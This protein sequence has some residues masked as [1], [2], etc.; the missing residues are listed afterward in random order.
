MTTT[1]SEQPLPSDLAGRYRVSR[2]LGNGGMGWVLLAHD[3]E[4]NGQEVALKLLYPQLVTDQSS[5]D[6]FRREVL[7]ARRLIH[8]NIVRTYNFYSD[9]HQHFL[10]MEYVDA[11]SLADRLRAGEG[12]H[13]LP[14]EECISVLL[15]IAD[16]LAYAH[17]LGVVHLDLKPENILCAGDGSAKIADFGIAQLL[18]HADRDAEGQTVGTPAYMAPEQ[19]RGEGA[20]PRTDI[21][22][23]GILTFELLTGAA[24]FAASTPF[25][26]AMKH[27]NDPLPLERLSPRDLPSWILELLERCTAKDPDRRLSSGVELRRYLG[28]HTGNEA[29]PLSAHVPLE[30][31]AARPV[32]T[33][34]GSIRQIRARIHALPLRKRIAVRLI[35]VA[36]A[37]ALL[38]ATARFQP[39][40]R[41]GT[42]TAALMLQKVTGREL[43]PL[44]NLLNIK[45][46]IHH[47]EHFH[48]SI[49]SSSD[50]TYALLQ[51]GV[52]PNMLTARDLKK[53][54]IREEPLI[55]LA[56][57]HF[58]AASLRHLLEAGADP[59]RRNGQGETAL[60]VSITQSNAAG[61][62]LLLD[63][64][65]D[66]NAF[67]NTMS[68]LAAAIRNNNEQFF[69]KLLAHGAD[70][71]RAEND[72]LLYDA[73]TTRSTFML[74]RLLELGLDPGVIAGDYGISPAQFAARCTDCA[75]VHAILHE[76]E[77][78]KAQSAREQERAAERSTA[79]P[80]AEDLGS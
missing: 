66:P 30:S 11:G 32:R 41:R 48:H 71:L 54:E 20:T 26:L 59:N 23:F 42:F 2:A 61:V 9:G 29:P 47:P 78:K 28:T 8:P 62:K 21:Y 44:M 65:A 43:A 58:N 15:S 46:S 10:A 16:G 70:P 31:G 75:A 33:R 18:K 57:R 6:R 17:H 69:E 73:I 79:R 68:M 5:L 64:G 39:S 1:Y 24:P 55:F 80:A 60:Y 4:L 19:F 35:G 53:P 37:A 77:E 67:V 72:T 22:A 50:E 34:S 38:I 74:K 12:R 25:L 40:V 13:G 52:D 7:I 14:L 3:S 27:L 56:A 45:A 51:V 63:G 36:I 49:S 76:W